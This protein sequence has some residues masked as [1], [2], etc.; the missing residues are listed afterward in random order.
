MKT[1]SNRLELLSCDRPDAAGGGK[2]DC[3]GFLCSTE[4]CLK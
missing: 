4:I 3:H 2:N 1:V